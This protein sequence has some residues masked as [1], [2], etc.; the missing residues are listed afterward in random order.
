MLGRLR[1]PIKDCIQAYKELSEK[2]F[3]KRNIIPRVSKGSL[4]PKF[5]EKV[6]ESILKAI[7]KQQLGRESALLLELDDACRVW[8]TAKGFLSPLIPLGLWWHI[9]KIFKDKLRYYD[10]IVISK[11]Q[12]NSEYT[13]D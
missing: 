6:L 2:V 13:P 12:K 5:D 1:M 3:P 10:H 4:G 8:V 7:I 11:S 9:W